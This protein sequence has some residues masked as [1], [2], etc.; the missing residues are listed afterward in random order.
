MK[1]RFYYILFPVPAH[2]LL[3]FATT[4]KNLEDL[5][6]TEMNQKQKERKIL[7]DLTYRW[8]GKK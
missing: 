8:N 3:P 2:S 7:Q 6:L 1:A 4:K 5:K